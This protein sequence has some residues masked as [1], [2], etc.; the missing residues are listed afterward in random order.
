MA[1]IHYESI[2]RVPRVDVFAFYQD[3]NN[4]ALLS[5]PP[6]KTKIVHTDGA[7]QRGLELKLCISLLFFHLKWD[8]Y[9]EAYQPPAFFV[10][11]QQKGPFK[12]WRHVHE[13]HPVP[14]GTKLIDKVDYELFLTPFSKPVKSLLMNRLLT[15]YFRYR[16]NKTRALLEG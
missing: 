14:E 9:I 16:H 7:M 12:K 3:V 15:S 11:V 10:D 6:L 2:V 1:D 8:A 5:K 4:L 13:F